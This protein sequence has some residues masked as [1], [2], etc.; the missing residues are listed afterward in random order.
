MSLLAPLPTS[1]CMPGRRLGISRAAERLMSIAVVKCHYH[2]QTM[3]IMSFC[4]PR[5]H[6]GF[7]ATCQSS[8]CQQGQ[9]CAHRPA[10]CADGHRPRFS[11]SDYLHSSQFSPLATLSGATSHPYT[12][13]AGLA[14]LHP[15]GGRLAQAGATSVPVPGFLRHR[16]WSL[17]NSSRPRSGKRSSHLCAHILVSNQSQELLQFVAQRACG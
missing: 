12:V 15:P 4:R 14:G 11:G 8:C 17:I 10:I 1:G 7:P 16:G 5:P 13:R 6:R 9:S 3:F 2:F